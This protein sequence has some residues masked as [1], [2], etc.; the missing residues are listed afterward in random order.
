MTTQSPVTP[1]AEQFAVER[2]AVLTL[3]AALFTVTLAATIEVMLAGNQQG[4]AAVYF[5]L[6]I[7]P[8]IMF[9]GTRGQHGFYITLIVLIITLMFCIAKLG[10]PE[11][12]ATG[13][14]HVTAGQK[15]FWIAG[16]TAYAAICGMGIKLIQR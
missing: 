11:T 7:V 3:L 4:F 13:M 12:I 10:S 1:T 16:M 14:S 5:G 2:F 9:F 15:M 8:A 6:L